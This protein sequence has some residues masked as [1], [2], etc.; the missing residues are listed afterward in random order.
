M[1]TKTPWQVMTRMGDDAE[2]CWRS[3]D[4]ELVTFF[5]QEQASTAVL[6]HVATCLEAVDSGHMQSAPTLQD[7][8]LQHNDGTEMEVVSPNMPNAT[9][10]EYTHLNSSGG[11]SLCN[12]PIAAVVYKATH[13]YEVG[14][15]FHAYPTDAKEQQRLRAVSQTGVPTVFLSEHKLADKTAK[16][17]VLAIAKSAKYLSTTDGFTFTR[18]GNNWTDGDIIV[19]PVVEE[20]EAL[21]A[22]LD[23]TKGEAS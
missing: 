19:E 8:Y 5:N 1:K 6:E 16:K 11:T 18:Q 21:E 23:L 15:I 22:V 9:F 7:F 17:L 2:N 20:L 10:T 3:D 12:S 13:D 14:W 4:G